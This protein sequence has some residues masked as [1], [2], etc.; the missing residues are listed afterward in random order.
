MAQIA[1]K[2]TA[3]EAKGHAAK[4]IGDNTYV[5][6]ICESVHTVDEAKRLTKETDKVFESGGFHVKGWPLNEKLEDTVMIN[7]SESQPTT[8]LLQSSAE[9]KVL[10]IVWNHQRDVFVF[11]VHPPNK[12]TLTKRTVL[13]RAKIMART[14]LG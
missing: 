1:L 14:K 5:D 6:D 11:K 8:K 12:S 7:P 10:G 2:I 9:E 13:I 3:E 4:V